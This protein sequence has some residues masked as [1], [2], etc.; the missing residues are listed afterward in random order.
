MKFGSDAVPHPH[1]T[2]ITNIRESALDLPY[3][4]D[5]S[6]VSSLGT[7]WPEGFL[8][9]EIRWKRNFLEGLALLGQVFENARKLSCH[10]FH[11]A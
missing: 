3:R 8:D 10:E 11:V 6:A 1:D 7:P 4:Q 9:L 2:H 5:H